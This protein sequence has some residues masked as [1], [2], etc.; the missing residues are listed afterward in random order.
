MFSFLVLVN[1]ASETQELRLWYAAI[2]ISRLRFDD[3]V[4]SG[5]M[6]WSSVPGLDM[7]M[8]MDM[9]VDDADVDDEV[10]AVTACRL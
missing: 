6:R 2:R 7:D 1:W 10:V 3:D 4:R 5:A 8:S 9:D